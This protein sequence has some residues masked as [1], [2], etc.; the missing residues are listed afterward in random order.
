MILNIENVRCFSGRHRL[1]IRRLTLLVGENSSGKST[2]LALLSALP[3]IS[4]FPFRPKFNDP[5]YNLGG[6]ST[7]VSNEPRST[8]QRLS[9][10]EQP[11]FCIGF[12]NADDTEEISQVRAVYGSDGNEVVLSE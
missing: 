7:I 10:T 4:G 11:S 8:R 1:E 2:D 3:D 6:F 5:P 9:K 12:E